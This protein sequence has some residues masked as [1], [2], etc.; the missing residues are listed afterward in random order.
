MKFFKT[1]RENPKISG[2]SICIRLKFHKRDFLRFSAHGR[3]RLQLLYIMKNYTQFDWST[4][5]EQ[6]KSRVC[7]SEITLIKQYLPIYYIT[8]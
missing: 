6:K 4:A 8:G 3:V 7:D 1:K 2:F 5:L